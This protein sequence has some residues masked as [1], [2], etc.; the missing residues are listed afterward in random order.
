MRSVR[1]FQPSFS[2][3]VC[4][5]FPVPSFLKNFDTAADLIRSTG[6]KSPLQRRR[7]DIAVSV[8]PPTSAALPP[9]V[10]NCPDIPA[11]LRR[12][13]RSP[14]IRPRLRVLL[15]SRRPHALV[16]STV[17]FDSSQSRR[18]RVMRHSQQLSRS[19]H[20]NRKGNTNFTLPTIP[21]L[22]PSFERLRCLIH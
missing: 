3:A 12:Q 11:L 6:A 14:G 17:Q 10:L 18:S 4:K 2:V 22:L 7:P 9:V 20:C 21:H 1:C 19:N 8:C 13:L 5:S 15:M 16:D